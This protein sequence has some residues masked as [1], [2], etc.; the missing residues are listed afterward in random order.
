MS[1]KKQNSEDQ[2]KQDKLSFGK[3]VEKIVQAPKPKTDKKKKPKK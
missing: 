3:L 2:P 1:E